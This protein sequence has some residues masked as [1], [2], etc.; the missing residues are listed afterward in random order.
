M[1]IENRIVIINGILIDL[2]QPFTSVNAMKRHAWNHQSEEEKKAAI[3]AGKKQYGGGGRKSESVQ[4]NQCGKMCKGL[5]NLKRH[6]ETHIDQSERLK[7]MCSICGVLYSA[8][9]TLRSHIKLTHE[10]NNRLQWLQ[11][12]HPGCQKKYPQPGRLDKHMRT[13]TGEKPYKCPECGTGFSQSTLLKVHMLKHKNVRPFN[14]EHCDMSF[15]RRYHLQRHEQIYHQSDNPPTKKQPYRSENGTRKPPQR[16]T[17]KKITQHHIQDH[18]GD[19]NTDPHQDPLQLLGILATEP[20][21]S[22]RQQPKRSRKQIISFDSNNLN[23]DQGQNQSGS[24]DTTTV[25]DPH[26]QLLGTI[27]DEPLPPPPTFTFTNSSGCAYPFSFGLN[28]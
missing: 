17:R 12:P 9:E 13:H 25:D 11:C 3:A 8:P 4:C 7:H 1:K 24:G 14:C 27:V 6:E 23:P 18:S 2:L 5:Y 16:R 22:A 21:T 20:P 26:E 28:Q 19:S 10:N 15:F